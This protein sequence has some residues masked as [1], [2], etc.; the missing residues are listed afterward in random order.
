[1]DRNARILVV[2]DNRSIVRLIEALLQKE[3][4][5]VLTAFDG[6]VGLR[7]AQ[8]ERPDLVILDIIMPKMDGY[9]VARLL[10]ANPDTATI[11][12]L[13]LTVKGQVDDPNLDSEAIETGIREQMDGYEAG[14]TEF[15]NKPIKAKELLHRVKTL[16]WFGHLPVEETPSAADENQGSAY[17]ED[18]AGVADVADTESVPA[19]MQRI[20]TIRR[21]PSD[22]CG[23]HRLRSATSGRSIVRTPGEAGGK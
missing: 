14:A 10:Q 18:V 22:R 15:L 17:A 2:D 16:L 8:E 1:M 3:G 6:L 13:M 4:F 23:R 5:T 19:G 21:M 7:K 11:P 20:G 9:E 12:L